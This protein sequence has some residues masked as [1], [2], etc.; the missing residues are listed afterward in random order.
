MITNIGKPS[1]INRPINR[2]YPLEVVENDSRSNVEHF[3]VKPKENVRVRPIR[4]A[5]LNADL[6]RRLRDEEDDS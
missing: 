6:I 5:A 3:D 1:F 4:N 2:L